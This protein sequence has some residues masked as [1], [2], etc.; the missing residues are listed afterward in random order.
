MNQNEFLEP[1]DFVDLDHP[2]VI[3]YAHEIAGNA[4]T[5]KQQVLTFI[6]LF[7][8]ISGM[9]L[10]TR[11]RSCQLPR[12]RLVLTLRGWCVPKQPSWRRAAE[13]IIFQQDPDTRMS[14]ITWLRSVS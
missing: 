8:T 7:E 9:T 3:E 5:D 14:K 11:C 2:A 4:K 12:Q 1:G 6:T 10:S 13:F